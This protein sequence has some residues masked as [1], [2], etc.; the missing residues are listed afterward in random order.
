M[1]PKVEAALTA[2][3]GGTRTVVLDGRRP[4]ALRE[5]VVEDPSGK[6]AAGTIIG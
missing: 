4:H 3:A 2:A 6:K 1:I 5:A